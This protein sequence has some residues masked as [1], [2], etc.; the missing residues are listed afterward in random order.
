MD[1][2]LFMLRVA[3]KIL[4][5]VGGF[6][7]LKYVLRNGSQTM[8]DILD[9]ISVAAKAV[10]HWIRKVCIGYLRKESEAKEQPETTEPEIELDDEPKKKET[11]YPT[12]E[13]FV[14]F[15]SDPNHQWEL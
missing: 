6:M 3:W 14:A 12:Y 2:I 9:T 7:I 1:F 11:K 13:E 4:A 8:R 5:I 15:I 10:G